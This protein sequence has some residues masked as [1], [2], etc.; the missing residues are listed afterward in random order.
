MQLYKISELSVVQIMDI[1]F[2]ILEGMF[3]YYLITEH[4]EGIRIQGNNEKAGSY[5]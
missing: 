1:V 3:K 2:H 4:K 5:K